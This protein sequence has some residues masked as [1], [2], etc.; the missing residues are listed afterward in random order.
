MKNTA[1]ILPSVLCLLPSALCLLVLALSIHA[2]TASSKSKG[3]T[4]EQLEQQVKAVKRPASDR[5]RFN[6][7]PV[8]LN[9][10]PQVDYFIHTDFTN[11]GRKL[12]E[13]SL[14]N[15][16]YYIAHSM[17][18]QDAGDAYGNTR[19]IP[20]KYLEKQLNA[21]LASN[22]YRPYD[23]EYPDNKPTQVFLFA[24]GM[25]NRKNMSPDG[26][27]LPGGVY[28]DRTETDIAGGNPL[29]KVSD[30]LKN[31]LDRAKIV[32]G[33]KFAKEFSI[34]VGQQLAA[35]PGT[36]HTTEI[37]PLFNFANR[38]ETTLALIYAIFNDCYYIVVSSYDLES[39]RSNQRKLLWTTRISTTARGV[40]FEETL[41]IMI[42]N[43]AYY[44]GRETNG[45]EI[46]LKRAYKRA[47]VE[48]GEP[49]VIDFISG[50]SAPAAS[51]TTNPPAAEIPNSK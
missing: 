29:A 33:L 41:P 22:G 18:Q 16:V 8:G 32:G 46:L 51:G 17:N 4:I 40:S 13:P 38:D 49:T 14:E 20:F 6:L 35:T 26:A 15:P 9:K 12:P 48:I 31:F 50:S 47:D 5:W 3:I 19:E 39:I 34:A 36:L 2:Q 25:Q 28:L 1:P 43:G 42:Q 24:W 44:F 27:L 45:P 30:D 11:A 21:A 7:L 37:G 10:N 23:P